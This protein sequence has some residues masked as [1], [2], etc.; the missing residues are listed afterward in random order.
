MRGDADATTRY[1]LRR[2]TPGGGDD[3][4]FPLVAGPNH[5]GSMRSNHVVLPESGVSRQHALLE[6]GP[7]SLIL[8][9]LASKNGTFV[10]GRRIRSGVVQPGDELELGKIRLLLEEMDPEDAELAFA[11]HSDGRQR[12]PGPTLRDTTQVTRRYV[13]GSL[14]SRLTFLENFVERLCL[15]PRADLIGALRLLVTELRLLGAAIV[16]LLEDGEAVM[17]ATCGDFTGQTLDLALDA[18]CSGAR[19]IAAEDASLTCASFQAGQAPP[20]M[21]SLL[22][23]GGSDP[24]G[25]LIAGEVEAR[26]EVE[27]LLRTLVRLLDRFRPRPVSL[28]ER[29]PEKNE[30]GLSFPAGH[31]LG[32]SAAMVSLY[33]QMQ[34]LVRSDLPVLIL[35]ETGVG[36]E[37]LARTLHLSSARSQ[38]PF[39]AINCAAIPTELLEAELF[40]IAGGVATGVKARP[41]KFQQAQGGTLFL[42][43]IGD[44][45]PALQ[46]KLLRALQEKEV[47]SVGGPTFVVDVRVVS[48]TNTDLDHRIASGTFRADLFYRLSGYSLEVPPLRR[49]QE[50]IP[51]LAEHFLRRSATEAGKSIRGVTV[52]A[53]HALLDYSW[54]GNV[55]ELEHEMRRL[56]YLCREGQPID[57]TLLSRRILTATRPRTAED[58]HGSGELNL[59]SAEKRL[60]VRAL[61]SSNGVLVQAAALLGISRDALRR[62]LQRYG[63][64]AR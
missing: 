43:E 5:I 15:L 45:L 41:G 35:G 33:A 18:F 20:L 2:L 4:T 3:I 1:R 34:S 62:R 29:P 11:V 6:V 26:A 24:L 19:Q 61:E 7:L 53:L 64:E 39:V 13:P 50:D 51:V 59:E 8:R 22:V 44:M 58:D 14:T 10:N 12:T 9:D 30:T 55:R 49:R 40:G 38:G 17:L 37:Y 60:I 57:S 21:G 42:D 27:V 63:L 36:K 31:V 23:A 46:A 32:H 28:P 52:K 56:A 54:P 47:H 25:L 48:A 16:E